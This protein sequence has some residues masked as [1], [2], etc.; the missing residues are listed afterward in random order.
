MN[1]WEGLDEFLAVAECGSF[2]AA[3][4]R[5]RVSSSHVSRQVARLEDRLQARLFYSCLLYTSRCV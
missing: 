2:F 5:L 4:E 3:A 1:R